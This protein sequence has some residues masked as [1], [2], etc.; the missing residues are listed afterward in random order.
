MTNE[1]VQPNLRS[2][3]RAI[4]RSALAA[5]AAAAVPASAT[6]AEPHLD[7][8]LFVLIAETRAF[9]LRLEAANAAL[10]A[11][12]A[13]LDEIESFRRVISAAAAAPGT[14]RRPAFLRMREIVA[15]WDARQA[16][17]KRAERAAGVD[18]A[19]ARAVAAADE[20]NAARRRVARTPAMTPAGSLA[21][22]ELVAHWFD[23]D[24]I[25]DASAAD[26]VVASAALDA[27]RLRAARGAE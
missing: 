22:L 2:D 1:T 19:E 24:E 21:K 18:E 11:A 5:R 14:E 10:E 23:L 16:A 9:E 4:L 8:G 20:L 15:A 17:V 7:S 26:A 25:E 27:G 3:R 12:N 13:A 6:A